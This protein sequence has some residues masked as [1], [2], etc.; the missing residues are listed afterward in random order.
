MQF[1]YGFCGE[2][3]LV[4]L[5]MDPRQRILVAAYLRVIAIQ[6]MP[7]AEYDG[8][9]PL[10]AYFNSFNAIRSNSALNYCMFS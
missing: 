6:Q 3:E 9:D 7:T 4:R 1:Q 8:P 5:F 10:P 2:P